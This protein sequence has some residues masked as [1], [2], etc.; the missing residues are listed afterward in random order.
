MLQTMGRADYHRFRFPYWDWR[1]EIQR[2][3]GLPSE[4]LFSFNRFGETRNV[5]NRPIV[6]G[7]LV[8]GWNTICIETPVEICNPNIVT[9]VL[10]RCPLTDDPYL[11]HSSN[12]DW[13]TMQQVN[14]I[15]EQTDYAV[16]AFDGLATESLSGRID[17]EP[18]SSIEECRQNLYCECIPGGI[19]CDMPNDSN[20]SVLLFNNGVH[21]KVQCL[22]HKYFNKVCILF[23]I[24]SHGCQWQ[25]LLAFHIIASN[26]HSKSG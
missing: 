12:P 6:F 14:I 23:I 16:P 5:S 21:P 4:Q 11:C 24:I 9:G 18:L 25:L 22:V 15:L 1:G 19:N 17:V 7:D 8:D 20:S 26:R 13:P 3:Y 2:S 10:Q